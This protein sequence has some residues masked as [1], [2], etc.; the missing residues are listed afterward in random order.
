MQEE[1]LLEKKEELV[2]LI[3][4][5]IYDTLFGALR[6][7]WKGFYIMQGSKIEDMPN[8]VNIV[9]G[10]IT[11]W[12]PTYFNQGVYNMVTGGEDT[13]F[14]E[15]FTEMKKTLNH[16]Y[17]CLLNIVFL[18]T[19]GVF[20]KI[21]LKQLRFDEQ[22]MDFINFHELVT[23]LF[24][25][26][27]EEKIASVNHD[28]GSGD[29][30]ITKWDPNEKIFRTEITYKEKED[31]QAEGSEEH[32]NEDHEHDH[33]NDDHKHEDASQKPKVNFIIG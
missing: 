25:A 13:Y 24:E 22:K 30:D 6:G 5:F 16:G 10:Y 15:K 17:R 11:Q 20:T 8:G 3:D 1:I 18:S 23:P 14:M 2:K 19:F 31:G 33:Q 9:Q 32:G 28:C 4:K 26:R 7:L 12:L 29:E 21:D 27:M